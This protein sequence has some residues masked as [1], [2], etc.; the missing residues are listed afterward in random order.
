MARI[1][2]IK[3]E[4][5]ADEKLGPL[6][7]TTRL[8]FLALVSLAD[9]AGRLLDNVKALDGQI[10]AY[11]SETCRRSLD[12]LST[13]GRIQRGTTASGQAVIQ[14]V[15]WRHQKIDKPNLKGALPE[16]Q[17]P[18]VPIRHE[19]PE[20]STTPRRHLDDE[21][22]NHTIIPVPTTYVPVPV[23]PTSANP[24]ASRKKPRRAEGEVDS[25]FA[26]AWSAY[27]SREGSN[28]RLD[29]LAQWSARVAAGVSPTELLD[30]VRRYSAF[31]AAAG[32]TGT[33]YVMQAARFFGKSEHWKDSYSVAMPAPKLDPF[34]EALERHRSGVR[35]ANR[36]PDAKD[37]TES[38][39]LAPIPPI[40]A[41]AVV[42][43][44][45][46]RPAHGQGEGH[47]A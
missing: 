2:T 9:D 26:V 20:D 28:N 19:V 21:P 43:F 13:I 47:A 37:G 34:A 27:P 35:A 32:K 12:E 46:P 44:A 3:P 29:A 5:W 30:G 23:P 16:I 14:V 10:F 25:D 40:T 15:N 22:S 41:L 11:T 42:S 17:N 18:Q 6:D 4:F 1:R 45:D 24:S 33:S 8:V 36:L 38:A 31:C 39:H 7:V